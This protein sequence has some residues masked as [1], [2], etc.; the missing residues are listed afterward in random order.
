M[1]D[2][3]LEAMR[4]CNSGTKSHEANNTLCWLSIRQVTMGHTE[5][6]RGSSDS[7]D[8][9]HTQPRWSF[10]R[11][12]SC[13]LIFN[14]LVVQTELILCEVAGK[15]LWID[16]FSSR[17]GQTERERERERERE[18]LDSDNMSTGFLPLPSSSAFRRLSIPEINACGTGC[19]RG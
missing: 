17:E 1:A 19:Y 4:L 18:F 6:D 16:H 14:V 12:R 7:N 11:R 5:Q 13:Q 2:P 8:H 15:E 9:I 10:A 3:V